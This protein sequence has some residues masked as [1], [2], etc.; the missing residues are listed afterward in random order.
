MLS[1]RRS[2]TEKGADA[3]RDAYSVVGNALEEASKQGR[4]KVMQIVLPNR[5]DCPAE[6][7]VGAARSD[8]IPIIKLKLSY[9]ININAVGQS[10]D[11]RC[12][13]ALEA[14]SEMGRSA[15]AELF[16]SQEPEPSGSALVFAVKQGEIAIVGLLPRQGLDINARVTDRRCQFHGRIGIEAASSDLFRLDTVGFLLQRDARTK[17]PQLR[18]NTRGALAS[19]S[20]KEQECVV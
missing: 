2:I 10:P 15:T 13:T 12:P 5:A 1:D 14:A 17:G 3:K 18:G 8:H 4:I 6:A 7:L 9:G 20:A 11:I 19:R 16:L